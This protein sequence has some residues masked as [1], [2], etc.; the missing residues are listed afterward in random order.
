MQYVQSRW[1]LRTYTEHA[2]SGLPNPMNLEGNIRFIQ[3][4]QLQRY[5]CVWYL[6]K[7]KLF[8]V[9]TE[10]MRSPYVHRACWERATKPYEL[11]GEYTIYPGSRP[12]GYPHVVRHSNWVFAFDTDHFVLAIHVAIWAATRQNQQSES[13]SLIRVFA[14][15]M[16]KAWVLS[17]PS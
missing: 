3:V 4:H 7:C 6:N 10:Q 17:Y 15:R 14:V 9:C 2:A 5:T 11:G 12:A 8:A 16:K 13:P 1:G